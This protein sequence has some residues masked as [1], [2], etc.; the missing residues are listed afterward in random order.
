MSSF[1]YWG[2]V[3]FYLIGTINIYK[4]SVKSICL[5]QLLVLAEFSSR[6]L[7][8]VLQ[9]DGSSVPCMNFGM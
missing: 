7:S 3:C 8:L 9:N 4:V 6:K 5:I 2:F 1:N